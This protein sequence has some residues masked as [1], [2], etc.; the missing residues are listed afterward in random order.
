MVHS[1][2]GWQ[3]VIKCSDNVIL[4]EENVI[5]RDESQEGSVLG[6]NVEPV[7]SRKLVPVV[8]RLNQ[9]GPCTRPKI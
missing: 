4:Q 2:R 3:F 5:G 9:D 7:I 6:F 8:Q 1:R